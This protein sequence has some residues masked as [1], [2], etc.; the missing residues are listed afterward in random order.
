MPGSDLQDG[1]QQLVLGKV[2]LERGLISA[3]QLRDALSE[4]ARRVG[5][6]EPITTSLGSILVSKGFLTDQQL[7]SLLAEQSAERAVEKSVALTPPPQEASIHVTP[8]GTMA[9]VTPSGIFPKTGAVDPLSGAAR[10]GKYTLVKELGRGGMGVVY[11]ALDTELNRR[12]A[13]KL[14]LSSPTAD[15]K[16]VALEE[17]R[18][19]RESQLSARL[20]HSNIV[21]VF[22]AGIIDGRR[23][24]AMELI[25]GLSLS[26]W[27]Q[28]N[29]VSLK[30]AVEALRNVALAVHHAHE[31]GILH[32]DL[33][34]RNVLIGK[35]GQPYVTDFGLAK[36]LGRKVSD[37]LTHSGMVVGTP[38]YMSP[39]QAQ[40]LDK[41]DWR[42]DI[43]SLGV[44]LYE[45]LTGQTPFTGESPIEILMKVVKD[46]VPLPTKIA[47]PELVVALDKTIE[48]I[49]LKALAKKDRDRYVT[50]KAFA[51]DITK[52]LRGES[53]KVSAPR[54][55]K[56]SYGRAVMLGIAGGLFAVLAVAV[57]FLSQGGPT[58]ADYLAKA[59]IA[60]TEGRWEDAQ[61]QYMM[62]VGL[63]STNAEAIASLEEVRIEIKRTALA[64]EDELRKEIRQKLLEANQLQEEARRREEEAM[65]ARSGAERKE[66][67]RKRR[68]AAERAQAKLE[69]ARRAGDE[70]RRSTRI[71]D[72][73]KVPVVP[74]GDPWESARDLLAIVDPARDAV[75]G[76][77]SVQDG[78]LVSGRSDHAR[79]EIPYAPPAE[80]D[81]RVRFT[82]MAGSDAVTLML[83]GA[84]QPFAF[85]IGTAG[86]T[87]FG[88][89]TIGG[90]R[91]KLN[92]STVGS[93]RCL[94]NGRTYTAV[95]QV[96]SDGV[97]AFL[98]D[99]PLTQW[100]TEDYSDMKLSEDWD[101]RGRPVLGLGS[102]R[103][104]TLFHRVE[105]RMINGA[106]RDAGPAEVAEL[107]GERVNLGSLKP[108]L[109]AEYYYGTSFESLGVRKVVPRVDFRWTEGPLWLGGPRDFF[110]C[111]FLGYLH[112]PR[113]GSYTF[114]VKGDD[115]FRLVIDG[116]QLVS[117]WRLSTQEAPAVVCRLRGGLHRFELEHFEYL[118]RASLSISWT[119][120]GLAR[121]APISDRSLYH[122][123]AEGEVFVASRQP[124]F[125]TMLRG[126]TNEVTD[127]AFSPDG[128][129]LATASKDRTIRLWNL[130][131]RINTGTFSGHGSGALA[132]AFS[133]DG[134]LLASGG[135][136]KMVRLWNIDRGVESLTLEGHTHFVDAV[137]F[138]PDG[139]TLA[140]AS[141]DGTIRLWD[142]GSGSEI[143][144]LKGHEGG[145]TCV[146]FLPGGK[147][148]VS[149]S[150][151]HTLREWDIEKATELRKFTG[152]ADWVEEIAL[153]AHG[154]SLA[155]ASRD[156]RILI[157][158][159]VS[160]RRIRD[161]PGHTSE[162]MSL[163]F[164]RKGTIL[165]S[166]GN[167]T[168]IRLWDTRTGRLLRTLPGHQ[169]SVKAVGFG[170]DGR[171]MAT[172]SFDSTLRLWQVKGP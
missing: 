63:D 82:R 128:R 76:T 126:H 26:Q 45:I 121:M 99:R 9:G 153:S 81:V 142:V 139:L 158:D 144:V 39:E 87:A 56:G 42:T 37:S 134:K 137:E 10:L 167:D 85:V 79:L 130:E 146:A 8:S 54:Q 91:A 156:G 123:P 106:G 110:S 159:L 69:E 149:G 48:N 74:S 101:L 138:S 34:P 98:D 111:R 155:S 24:L 62:A 168:M 30:Q 92:P 114:A 52:W 171:T 115:G 152:H 97:K 60:R 141:Y 154:S 88:F 80:Y 117:K 151:D 47:K 28:E 157:W 66:A 4:R 148:L 165:A 2:L 7:V 150:V 29:R 118:N 104:P 136:D 23:F 31:Q 14:M 140:S 105:I 25:E 103:S 33:K 78:N 77:W 19:I 22:E 1:G 55:K 27:R 113:T 38:A 12:C 116:V 73:P 162:V 122:D 133:P 86:N 84:G 49:C 61:M 41:I 59:R 51:D 169:G 161:L 65:K 107:E 145:V 57:Y 46:P 102:H 70:L 112:V 135:Y 94:D 44:M 5:S 120:T 6:G 100:N 131:S 147:R 124:E 93:S 71:T 129:M 58:A 16:E 83:A 36:T 18:F 11:E 166:G 15:P 119:D 95:V 32:R 72:P 164:G 109:V 50:A 35:N 68:E 132:V 125:R 64:R 40:G 89:D 43:Y 17:E 53:V 170:P 67:E 143:R 13:L 127:L 108:G 75:W 20:K 3:D 21:T 172:G 90:A 96:R 163:A 160:G